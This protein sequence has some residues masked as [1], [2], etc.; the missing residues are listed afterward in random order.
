M[1]YRWLSKNAKIIREHIFGKLPF[2]IKHLAFGVIQRRI[3]GQLHGHGI[4]RHSEE[5]IYGIAER[6]LRAVSSLLGNKKFLLGSDVPSLVD[7]VLFAFVASAVWDCQ[8][9]P[10]AKLVKTELRN[11]ESHALRMKEM[12]YPDWDEILATR[13]AKVTA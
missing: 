13:A 4:G 10:Q 9:S 7:A 5:D 3:R 6:D 12:F 11:L 8:D 1:Y 2:L